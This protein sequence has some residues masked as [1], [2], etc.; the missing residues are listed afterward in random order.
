MNEAVRNSQAPR[1]AGL[2]RAVDRLFPVLWIG[3]YLLLPV[4]GWAAETFES[5]FDQRRDLEALRSVLADGHADA[6]A[7]GVIGPAYIGAAALLHWVIGLD[8]KDALVA[9]TRASYVLSVAAGLVLVR[10]LVVRASTASPI[11]SLA[12]QFGFLAL[13][14]AAGTWYWSD[15]PWSHFFAASLAVALYAVRFAPSRP[16]AAQAVAVGAAIALLAATRTFELIAVL[17]AWGIVAVT[18]WLLGAGP[19][20]V[21]LRRV[22]LGAASFV[23][24]TAVVYAGTGKREPFLHYAKYLDRQSGAVSAAEI[25][26]TPALSLDLLPVKLVQLFVDPCY[27]SL[28]ELTDYQT[29]GGDG[30]NLDLWSLPLSVQLPAL[31][32]LPLCIAAVALLGARVRRGGAGRGALSSA[33]RPLAEMTVAATGL[34]VGYAASTMTGPSHLRY[35]FARDFLLAALLTAVVAVALGA[36]GLWPLLGR[37]RGRRVSPEMAFVLAAAACAVGVVALSMAARSSGLPRIES[38]H[39]GAVTYDSA[40][41]GQRCRV[42]MEAT[43]SA[44]APISIPKSSTLTFGCGSHRPRFS[45]YLASLE[46]G[47]RVAATCFDPRLVAAWPTVMGLPAGSSELAAVGIRS[48]DR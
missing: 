15:V 21:G 13:V 25:A 11:V 18:A 29:G 38:R 47:V 1:L 41:D 12:S 2:V 36:R 42:G 35:G 48:A 14:F 6:I 17:L 46:D 43:T 40:C 7:D 45:I 24:V 44:G 19:P 31:V 4:S 39:L 33:W 28:C 16:G 10:V 27:L 26:E 5:W 3:L 20:R 9:L 30:S 23:A 22:L 8:P 37:A 32:L 34:V